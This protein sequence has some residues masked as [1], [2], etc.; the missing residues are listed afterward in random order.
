MG[1]QAA[2]QGLQEQGLVEGVLLASGEDVR[3]ALG[4]DPGCVEL[5]ELLL[6]DR[7]LEPPRQ[8]SAY[9]QT[10]TRPARPSWRLCL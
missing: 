8:D 5:R 4:L 1:Q 9:N 10:S 6:G 2:R 7:P 3:D